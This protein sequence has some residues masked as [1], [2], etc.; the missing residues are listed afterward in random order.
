MVTRETSW[1]FRTTEKV[2]AR[3]RMICRTTSPD[4][5]PAYDYR[6][7]VAATQMTIARA[8]RE[9]G[10]DAGGGGEEEGEH[11]YVWPNDVDSKR[12]IKECRSRPL[13]FFVDDHFACYVCA[14]RT[15]VARGVQFTE[16][17]SRARARSESTSHQPRTDIFSLSSW[18]YSNKRRQKRADRSRYRGSTRS[19]NFR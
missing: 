8:Q 10:G 2:H 17:N 19:C 13:R 4:R 15:C 7:S 3:S 16:R 9:Q 12:L 6:E 5:P 11:V 14:C 1:T 18:F